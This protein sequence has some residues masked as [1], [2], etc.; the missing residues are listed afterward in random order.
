MHQYEVRDINWTGNVA[1]MSRLQ[2][3]SPTC[4]HGSS[5]RH[6]ATIQHVGPLDAGMALARPHNRVVTGQLPVSHSQN[7]KEPSYRSG[8][9]PAGLF[10][11]DCCNTHYS[12]LMD[13]SIAIWRTPSALQEPVRA[14]DWAPTAYRLRKMVRGTISAWA[15]RTGSFYRQ[16]RM[17]PD[18]RLSGHILKGWAARDACPCY[19][20]SQPFR[21]STKRHPASRLLL[22]S[23]IPSSKRPPR[24]AFGPFFSLQ[25]S[26]RQTTPFVLASLLGL[27]LSIRAPSEAGRH[28]RVRSH[29]PPVLRFCI[30]GLDLTRAAWTASV[31]PR[32]SSMVVCGHPR[33]RRYLSCLMEGVC[34]ALIMLGRQSG[35]IQQDQA[36]GAD[37]QLIAR[38]NC[39]RKCTD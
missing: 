29:L 22:D 17:R 24:H 4:Q 3:R 10:F 21:R 34:M 18:E 7:A 27:G 35:T 14:R 16:G 31:T 2:S 36:Q 33:S 5:E 20:P 12:P 15:Q 32:A 8:V 26:L 11:P 30:S 28:P 9:R 1:I 19:D 25:P 23:S 37:R 13:R 39:L 38:L 6:S